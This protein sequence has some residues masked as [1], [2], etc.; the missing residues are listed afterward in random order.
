M[1][2]ASVAP[3]CGG[4][5]AA[6]C[7]GGPVAVGDDETHLVAVEIAVHGSHTVLE[8]ANKTVIRNSHGLYAH[9]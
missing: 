7:E 3:A 2:A 5:L 1:P 9:Y 8:L 6:A 4:C